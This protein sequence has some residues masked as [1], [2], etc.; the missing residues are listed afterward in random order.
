MRLDQVMTNKEKET[1]NSPKETKEINPRDIPSVYIPP[2]Q[3]KRVRNQEGKIVW[4]HKN[5][6]ASQLSHQ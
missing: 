2:N 3:I 1:K 4:V 5:V 6:K